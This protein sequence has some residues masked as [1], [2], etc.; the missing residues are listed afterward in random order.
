MIC[1]IKT[2]LIDI[3]DKCK[4]GPLF[5]IL[6]FHNNFK[7]LIASHVV[8]K[9]VAM[10]NYALS[11]ILKHLI[12]NESETKMDFIFI[13]K[14]IFH[15]STRVVDLLLDTPTIDRVLCYSNTRILVAI[16]S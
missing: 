2:L 15:S 3:S 5:D 4:L 16:P 8:T 13:W 6:K 11:T 7:A 10:H 9:G 12:S 14:F 1:V